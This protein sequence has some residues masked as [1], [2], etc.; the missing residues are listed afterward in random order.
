MTESFLKI[1]RVHEIE[2]NQNMAFEVNGTS[3]LVCNTKD[4]I[5][6]VENQC[7]HQMQP[8]EGG[9]IRS[10]FIFCP[11]HGQ[12]FNLKDGSPIGQLTDKPIKTFSVKVEDDDIYVSLETIAA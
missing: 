5:F 8:L 12:R 1:A 11:L 6:A 7:S 3:V 2:E 4:G 10:C 9:R